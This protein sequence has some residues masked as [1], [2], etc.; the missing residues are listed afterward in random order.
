MRKVV[1]LFGPQLNFKNASYGGGSGGYTRNMET[2]MDEFFSDEFIMSPCFHTVRSGKKTIY[3]L[4][5]I[6]FFIDVKRFI[7][8]IFSFRKNILVVHI[9][10]QYRT[11]TPREFAICFI[12]FLLKIPYLYEIKA[13]QFDTWYNRTNFLNKR[14]IKFII[15]KSSLIL[16]EGKRYIPFVRNIFNKESFYWPNF[17]PSKEIPKKIEFMPYSL[18]Q[19]EPL[20]VC[21]IGYCYEGKGVF[22][23]VLGSTEFQKKNNVAIELHLVGHES[24]EFKTFIESSDCKI[25][26]IRH[27]KQEHDQVL[28]ILR[29][30]HLF[31]LPTRHLGEGHNNS[32]N[33]A[34][35]CHKPII[36]TKNGFLTDI[37]S[38]S[39]A[40]FI[41]DHGD[42]RKAL[43]FFVS[44]PENINRMIDE[45][46]EFFL[47]K[48]HSDKVIP[49]LCDFYKEMTK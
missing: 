49:V 34:M 29:S 39:K 45:A 11:A 42:I 43:E 16:C 25:N 31:C 36:C 37:L 17:V 5:L 24:D 38:P 48:L 4:F 18:T 26:V 9:L 28:A 35:M 46:S 1:V 32:V 19:S 30:C 8:S 40:I 44:K 10:A 41:E 2:Y 27:G 21:F 12:C 3:N 20:K 14:M 33:E 15:S 7:E 6:R 23:L 13:G 22:D 47:S